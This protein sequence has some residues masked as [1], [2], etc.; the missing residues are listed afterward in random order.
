MSAK[1]QGK[2]VRVK[3]WLDVALLAY[4]LISPFV[5]ALFKRSRQSEQSAQ[6]TQGEVP[7]AQQDIRQRLNGLTLESWQWVAEQA[8]QLS[9]QARQ[10][11]AQSR[12]LSKALRREARQRRKLLVQVR[13]SGI[14]LRKDLLKRGE[15]LTEELVERGGKI[16]QNVL[17]LG[18][19]T[20]HDLAERR[21]EFTHELAKRSGQVTEELAKRGEHLLEPVRKRD[22][23][24]WAVVGF[25]VGLV[26][27]GFVTYRLVRSRMAQRDT[28]QDERIELPRSDSSKRG[29]NRPAGEIRHINQD[30]ASIAT[31]E[32]V[33]VVT[34]ERPA[35]A[36]FVGVVSTKLYYPVDTALEAEDLMYFISEEVAR[37][38][39]FTPAK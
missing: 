22:R 25:S 38:Q 6:A 32:I 39:G 1:N 17:E 8:Q 23:N 13:E 15:H 18:E 5:N 33:D 24:F 28:E 12:Q 19:K 35:D 16:T 10:L 11:Q 27:A 30:G 21:E 14:D 37:T 29:H 34:I 3:R 9:E 20:A 4:T 31:L 26:A 7:T 2:E 36:A